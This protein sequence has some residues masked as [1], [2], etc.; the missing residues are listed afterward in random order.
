[1]L[2]LG[3][4]GAGVRG[5]PESRAQASS[6]EVPG[7]VE[8]SAFRCEAVARRGRRDRSGVVPQVVAEDRS[9]PC[10]GASVWPGE[11]GLAPAA[12]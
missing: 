9:R 7:L 2:S 4:V 1:M 6:G 10:R 11:R 3:P 5:S 8:H 12:L